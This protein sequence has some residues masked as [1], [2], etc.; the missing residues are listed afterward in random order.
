MMVI[1]ETLWIA[2]RDITLDNTGKLN[3]K[4]ILLKHR[5]REFQQLLQ[6]KQNS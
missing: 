3:C 2:L 1:D 6:K 5:I 4:Y